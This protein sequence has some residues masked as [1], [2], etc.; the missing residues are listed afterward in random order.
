MKN[1]IAAGIC[2]SYRA[3]ILTG[4][5]LASDPYR[6]ALYNGDA[7]LSPLDTKYT[8]TGEIDAAGYSRG[9][10][11]LEGFSVKVGE[12]GAS[13]TFSPVT[14]RNVSISAD[15]A[16]I[17]NGRTGASV[18]VLNFGGLKSSTSGDFTI[19]FASDLITI[20]G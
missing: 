15:G 18:A 13:A 9:G 11:T 2:N 20:N 5:H 17:Y 16:M 8:N 3:E 4:Q 12:N 14:W 6:I 19:T 10:A 7:N 1:M